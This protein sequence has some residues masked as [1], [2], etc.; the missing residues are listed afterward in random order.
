MSSTRASAVHPTAAAGSG[1][2]P[3]RS[4][5]F[6]RL[7]TAQFTSNVGGWMQTVGAQWVMISL[8]HSALLISAIQAASSLPV[9]M[10]AIPAGA[11]GDL[12]D[13]RRLILITQI[14]MLLASAA[15]A[16]LAALHDLTP[17]VL[18]ALLFLI[19]CGT[20]ASAPTWQTLQP[21]LVPDDQRAPAIAL[22]S[23]NQNLAR[24]IGPAIGGLLLA[25][26]SAAVVFG[27]NAVSFIAVVA[28]IAVTAI[29]LRRNALPREH[30]LDAVR[31]GGRY[32]ANSPTLVALILRGVGFIFPAGALWALLPLVAHGR[33]HLGS[34]GYGL[35]LGCVGVGA[36][37]A[38][39]YGPALRRRLSPPAV[40]ALSLIS[41]AIP[42]VVLAVA[43]TVVLDAAA[44][45]LAGAAWITGIGL[46]GAAYQS[47][48]PAWVKARGM[49]YYLLAFQ[50]SN[51]I[52]A[53]GFGALA[54]SAGTPM[55][56]LIMA[57][58]LGLLSVAL[59]PL[60]LPT[61]GAIDLAP[62]DAWPLPAVDGE[63]SPSGPVMVEVTWSPAKEELEAFLAGSRD[64]RRVRKRTGAVKWRLYRDATD[65]GR[66]V[67][68]F[69]VGSWEEHSRQH[70]RL[71]ASDLTV[72][73]SLASLT[74]GPNTRSIRHLLS[75][76]AG[77]GT[78]HA[79]H[80]AP[81]GKRSGLAARSRSS[82]E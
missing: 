42:A 79:A 67:E 73:D 59:W 60:A 10:L 7:W 30:A 54:Q 48:M 52:G 34:T 70:S 76:G 40:Y 81:S 16:L 66:V 80:H 28:A 21:E 63:A 20:A 58:V 4:P 15:M 41:I 46:L 25:A 74:A 55:A 1:W 24:A 62:V 39:T 32:V 31:A 47:S 56:L 2:R 22:G 8:T 37:L 57:G 38:A 72:I 36:L 69:L 51:A 26:T 18:L 44:L 3:L 14:V 68:V 13:R 29:P 45:V 9:F 65:A 27:V 19:G 35:L 78:E 43:H 49:S 77:W 23:V 50:G 11:L 5:A 61:P 12:V 75:I 71:S 53:L 33:L 6:R 64:L 17:A 82:S